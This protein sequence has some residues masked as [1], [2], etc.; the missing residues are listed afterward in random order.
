MGIQLELGPFERWDA[1]GIEEACERIN[2]LGNGDSYTY[3]RNARRR[4]YKFL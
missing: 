2:K 3:S 4:N 1:I